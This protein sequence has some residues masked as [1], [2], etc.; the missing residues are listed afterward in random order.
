VAIRTSPGAADRVGLLIKWVGKTG[1]ETY[2]RNVLS[3]RFDDPMDKVPLPIRV[4]N[5]A[6]GGK[7]VEGV[8]GGLSLAGLV[9]VAAVMTDRFRRCDHDGTIRSTPG[10]FFVNAATEGGAGWGT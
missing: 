1:I 4:V 10:R 5:A 9:I 3:K 2:C 8:L 7:A 6:P